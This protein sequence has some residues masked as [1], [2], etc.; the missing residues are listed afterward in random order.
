MD[1]EALEKKKKNSKKYKIEN[2][3]VLTNVVYQKR[4]WIIEGTY[5]KLIQQYLKNVIFMWDGNPTNN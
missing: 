5:V 1:M 3:V 4:E 2:F